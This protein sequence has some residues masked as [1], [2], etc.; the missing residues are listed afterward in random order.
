M[1]KRSPK[2]LSHVWPLFRGFGGLYYAKLRWNRPKT[3]KAHICLTQC[4]EMVFWQS[5]ANLGSLICPPDKCVISFAYLPPL[6]FGCLRP[7]WLWLWGN[8]ALLGLFTSLYLRTA[9][10][11]ILW[12]TA[13]VTSGLAPHTQL[14]KS[15]HR[16]LKHMDY[17]Q[18]KL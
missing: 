11:H 18:F 2:S 6:T 17:P 4:K 10:L 7:S 9:T 13:Q 3:K 1:E 8:E 15:Q 14:Q 12:Q 5:G 16:A